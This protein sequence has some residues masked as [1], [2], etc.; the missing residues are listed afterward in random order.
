VL[1]ARRYR[2]PPTVVLVDGAADRPV[3]ERHD[4]T[5]SSCPAA[6][7]FQA[8]NGVTRV[9]YVPTEAMDEVAGLPQVDLVVSL[10]AWCFHLRPLA[11]L[12]FVKRHAAHGAVVVDVRRDRPDWHGELD[13]AL[14]YDRT[15]RTEKKYERRAYRVGGRRVG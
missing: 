10:Q 13:D 3:A 5:F 1:L 7:R 12:P 11:Y 8:A 15:L 4:R 9:V 6:L 14:V 2:P